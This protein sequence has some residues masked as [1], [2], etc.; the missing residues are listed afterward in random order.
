MK[1]PK[2]IHLYEGVLNRLRILFENSEDEGGI[3]SINNIG[4]KKDMSATYKY[5]PDDDNIYVDY[6]NYAKKNNLLNKDGKT[7]NDKNNKTPYSSQN[8]NIPLKHNIGYG[9]MVKTPENMDIDKVPVNGEETIDCFNLSML[10]DKTPTLI[11]HTYKGKTAAYPGAKGF[12]ITVTGDGGEEKP[13]LIQGDYAKKLEN[14]IKNYAPLRDFNP[15]WIIYPE[16]SSPFNQYIG[17]FLTKIFPNATLID[18]GTLVKADFW[19]IDYKTLIQLGLREIKG[20]SSPYSMCYS[21]FKETRD[22]FHKEYFLK[23][24]TDILEPRICKLIPEIRKMYYLENYTGGKIIEIPGTNNFI[25]FWKII[26][27]VKRE[28]ENFFDKISI[29]KE[30]REYTLSSYGKLIES[31]AAIGRTPEEISNYLKSHPELW[32]NKTLEYSARYNQNDILVNIEEIPEIENIMKEIDSRFNTNEYHEMEE[33]VQDSRMNQH[34]RIF[35]F[36]NIH[37]Y[38]VE[39]IDKFNEA[40]KEV[41]LPINFN[42]STLSEE[43]LLSIFRNILGHN[44]GKKEKVK[45]SIDSVR[46]EEPMISFLKGSGVGSNEGISK[47]LSNYETLRNSFKNGVFSFN[48]PS[49]LKKANE[50]DTVKNYPYVSRMSLYNQ[51]EFSDKIKEYPIKSTDRVLIID[52]NYATGAS[53]KNAANVIHDEIGIPYNSI[54]ALTPGDMGTSSFGGK[55]GAALAYNVAEDYVLRKFKNGDFKNIEN[56]PISYKDKKGATYATTLGKFMKKR[57]TQAEGNHEKAN[58]LRDAQEGNLSKTS[59]SYFTNGEEFDID[60]INPLKFKTKNLSNFMLPSTLAAIKASKKYSP[61]DIEKLILNAEHDLSMTT[62]QEEQNKLSYNIKRWNKMLEDLI[63]TEGFEKWRASNPT[64]IQKSEPRKMSDETLSSKINDAEIQINQLKQEYNNFSITKEEYDEE[65]RKINQNLKYW[66]KRLGIIDGKDLEIPGI[67]PINTTRKGRKADTPETL[68]AKIVKLS[69]L[70][71]RL[72]GAEKRKAEQDIKK[73]KAKIVT[74]SSSFPLTAA[75]ESVKSNMTPPI[76]RGPGRPRKIQQ[77]VENGSVNPQKT[78]FKVDTKNLRVNIKGE[79]S[80]NVL[81]SVAD[82]LNKNLIQVKGH[83][84][85]WKPS[86]VATFFKFFK[87]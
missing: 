77:P 16:S 24:L 60:N 74:L 5:L 50:T 15:N 20:V 2:R 80:L 62:D 44:K 38:F 29:R 47:Y 21:K 45:E 58:A 10:G 26:N 55:K 40:A 11:A 83:Y 72:Q 75:A 85:I 37:D 61:E 39:E 22:A 82:Y 9:D 6:T 19:G 8:P 14:L 25:S 12:T 56:T 35:I 33:F 53:F 52:D 66:K 17:S 73:W 18:N 86:E 69:N 46:K 79:N 87:V 1:K 13:N 36:N 68:K 63:G 7:F 84:G 54:K 51:F 4:N 41:G 67:E 78:S 59:S 81:K 48:M 28:G 3:F 23:Q 65:L 64:N 30:N 49:V 71:P 27:G 70:L 32:G 57:T 76:K 42:N 43:I 31:G 34:E